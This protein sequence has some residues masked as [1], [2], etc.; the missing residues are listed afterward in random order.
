M[1]GAA[2]I[3]DDPAMNRFLAALAAACLLAASSSAAEA[4]SAGGSKYDLGVRAIHYIPADGNSTWNPGALARWHFSDRLAA[5]GLFSY[6]RHA[7]PDTT[8]H[9]GVF[10]VSGLFYLGEGRLRGFVLAGAGY[11]ASRVEGPAYRRNI[12]RVG[13]HAGVGFEAALSEDYLVEADYRHVW[14][15]DIDTRTAAGAQTRVERSGEQLSIGLS[16]RF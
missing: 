4:P 10:Q 8:V 6:Q 3:S 2:R 5:E 14:L 16:R 9:A 7:F 13:P 12:G 1:P 15:G 11:F